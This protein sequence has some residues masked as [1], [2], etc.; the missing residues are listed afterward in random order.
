MRLV[1]RSNNFT[2]MRLIFAVLVV[3]SHSHAI[4]DIEEPNIFARTA[5]SF[6]VQCFFAISGY[7]VCG[8]FLTTTTGG[9]LARRVARVAPALIIA[10]AVSTWAFDFFDGYPRNALHQSN[11]PI[12]TITWEVLLYIILFF[13]GITG[14]LNRAAIGGAYLSCIVLL[15]ATLDPFAPQAMMIGL[16]LLFGGGVFLRLNEDSID[17]R[18]CGLI[19]ISALVL[20]YIPPAR[21]WLFLLKSAIPFVFGG[22][23]RFDHLQWAISLIAL[24]Y[25][26]VLVAQYFPVSIPVRN[27]YSYGVYL[28]AWPIQQIIVHIAAYY[29]Y[30]LTPLKVFAA[31]LPLSLICGALSWHLVERHAIRLGHMR[32]RDLRPRGSVSV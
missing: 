27:D 7:L 13:V 17:M 6:A 19:A 1:M 23:L 3:Y 32:W 8:S 11:G 22:T 5:G 29:G 20:F 31:A 14:L 26:L 10:Y 18:L 9:Y 24:P 28:F 16:F 2:L 25:A 21:E 15:F 12:W 4:I 30:P